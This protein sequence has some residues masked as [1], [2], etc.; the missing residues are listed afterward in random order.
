MGSATVRRSVKS[1][2]LVDAMNI[3]RHTVTLWPA[4]RRAR[5]AASP[6]IPAPVIMTFKETD[7]TSDTQFLIKGSRRLKDIMKKDNHI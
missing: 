4:L 2:S 1:I 7:M 5:P 6:P 3:E